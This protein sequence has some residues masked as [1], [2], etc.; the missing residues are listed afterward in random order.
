MTIKFTEEELLVLQQI[1]AVAREHGFIDEMAG[2]INEK[3]FV[4][5]KQLVWKRKEDSNDRK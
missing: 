5:Y 1:M 4:A 3:L 2:T